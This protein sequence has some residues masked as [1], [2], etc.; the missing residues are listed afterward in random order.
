MRQYDIY[1]LGIGAGRPV[2]PLLFDGSRLKIT[3]EWP[4]TAYNVSTH[5]DLSKVSEPY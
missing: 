2:A 5:Y 1:F 3:I 4:T